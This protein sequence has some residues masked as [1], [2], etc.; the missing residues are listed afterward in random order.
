MYTS[1]KKLPF[2]GGK[3]GRAT[4]TKTT[5]T[6]PPGNQTFSSID[7]YKIIMYDVEIHVV[8]AKQRG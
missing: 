3:H 8:Y 1:P 5:T 7:S 2:E 4:T 6:P